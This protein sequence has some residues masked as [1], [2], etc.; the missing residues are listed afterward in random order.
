MSIKKY[1][2]EVSLLGEILSNPVIPAS[3]TFAFGEEYSELYDLNILGSIALK[4]TTKDER[5]GNP[6]PRIAEAVSGVLNSVGLQNPGYEKVISEEIPKLRKRFKKKFIPNICGFS[7]DEYLLLVEAFS[8]ISD[9]LFLEINISCPNVRGGGL[10]FGTDPNSAY[11][12]TKSIKAVSEKPFFMKL[13]PNVR[14]ISEIAL[15]CEEGGAD[16]ISLVNTF[17][18]MSIDLKSRRPLLANITGGLSGPAIFPIA[19][20]MVYE[21]YKAVKIPLI[22]IGGISSAEDVL[23]MLFAGATAVQIGAYNL[24]NPY[25][26]KEIIEELPKAME[27]YGIDNLSD[28]IGGA[29]IGA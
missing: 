10:C 25:A 16:G 26:C 19:L 11:S 12:L 17:S 7:E 23:K 3:G 22:G 18:A 24:K 14:D 20:R 9:A 1:N 4:G 13:S 6:T 5:F 2:T 28:I 29:H 27:K 21:V 15:A 8:K